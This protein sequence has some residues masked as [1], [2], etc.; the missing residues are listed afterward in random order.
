MKAMAEGV[1]SDL[2][3]TF[4]TYWRILGN[5]REPEHDARFHPTRKWRMDFLWREEQV[6]VECQGAT[7]NQGKHVRGAGYANDCEK[8]NEAQLLGYTVIWLTRDMLEDNPHQAIGWV[9][10]AMDD[11]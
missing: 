8:L 3:R 7:W 1:K 10:E 6:C 2:E 5:G 11:D 9:L 4:E